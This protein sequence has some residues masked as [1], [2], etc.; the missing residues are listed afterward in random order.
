[1]SEAVNKLS[2]Y[3]QQAW[4]QAKHYSMW[5]WW[6]LAELRMKQENQENNVA[7]EQIKNQILTNLA[8]HLAKQLR[9]QSR[10]QAT[11]F[12]MG[13]VNP[14]QKNHKLPK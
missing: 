14:V 11:F 13:N 5:N 4:K 3:S 8:H 10:Q 9:Q 1:M 6:G 7:W 12:K 2:V